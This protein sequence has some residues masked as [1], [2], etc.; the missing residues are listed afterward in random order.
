M[1]EYLDYDRFV[2]LVTNVIKDD[3]LRLY[4]AKNPQRKPQVIVEVDV[5]SA[6]EM[7][8]RVLNKRRGNSNQ[9]FIE[10]AEDEVPEPGHC[11]FAFYKN[12]AHTNVKYLGPAKQVPLMQQT[13]EKGIRSYILKDPTKEDLVAIRRE[14]AALLV[15]K[16]RRESTGRKKNTGPKLHIATLLFSPRKWSQQL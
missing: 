10:V 13:F 14:M 9:Y 12:G 1:S 5:T 6:Y 4:E 15:I 2:F 3:H 8:K 16:L 11:F 7:N